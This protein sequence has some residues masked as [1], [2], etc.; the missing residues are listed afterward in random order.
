MVI[1]RHRQQFDPTLFT[2]PELPEVQTVVDTLR[3]RIVGRVLMRIEHLRGDI[4]APAGIDLAGLLDGRRV[5]DVRRR[6]K[7]IVLRLDDGNRFYFHLGM[8]GRLTTT[9]PAEAVA[10]HTHFRA[11]LDGARELR[12]SDPR[13]FGGIFWLGQIGHYR[14]LGP[15]PLSLRP[16]A[17][18]QRLTRTRRAIKTALLD[19]TII[20]GLGNIYADEILHRAA[21][22]PLMPA[23]AL[24]PEQSRR[25]NR[26]IK[27][28]LR[29]A[30]RAGGS[31]IRDYVDAAGRRGAFQT[32]HRVYDRAGQPCRTC[33]G[34]IVRIVVGGRSTHFCE[35][36]QAQTPRPAAAPAPADN[37]AT[38]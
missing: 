20:A 30:I 17:L 36:C 11:V 26:A 34:L 33:R 9:G 22:H 16:G 21:L 13:R 7:R 1:Y 38:R 14:G 31:S 23:S 18:H 25:L 6:A 12:F 32:L 35:R 29:R 2:V 27:L 8:T 4:V 19:Q 5:V 15:E 3:P 24:S 10:P 37:S 28:V